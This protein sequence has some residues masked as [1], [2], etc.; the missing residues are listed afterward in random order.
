MD[1]KTFEETP[2]DRLTQ[3]PRIAIL[4]PCHNE[5]LTIAKVVRDFR[6]FVPDAEIYVYDNNST[7]G[8]A[9]AAAAAGAIVRC[10]AMQGK[11]HVVRRMFRDI[12]ADLYLIVD[13][14]DTYDASLAPAMLALAAAEG[15]DLVNYVRRDSELAAYRLGHRFGNR[16]LAGIV[17]RIFGDRIQDM[18]SG[19]KLLSRR[20]VK[21]F[22][23]LAE[24]FDTE[25]ELTIH[26]LQLAMPVAHVTGP[27]KGRRQG[28]ASKL[29]TYRDGIRILWIILV[30]F[31]HERPMQLF[32]ALALVLA[33]SSIG[34]GL[35]VVIT[36]L[37]TGLVPRLPTALLATGLMLIA[38]LSFVTGLILDTVSRGRRENRMLAYLSHAAPFFNGS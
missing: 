25:T 31:K 8:T 2:R 22:P 14:D 12:E 16:L 7:D 4:L 35:P 10:E 19:Y 32:S 15:C 34:L 1:A 5:A 13:G 18:L 33:I 17:R 9:A 3:Q 37:H 24:G 20:F 29:N 26:A 23:A 6:A 38:A 28:S 27:Y 21:S 11:G 36:F 30:L